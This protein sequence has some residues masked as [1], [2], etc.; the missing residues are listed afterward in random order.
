MNAHRTTKVAHATTCASASMQ[1]LS[2]T[3]SLTLF[4]ALCT[5]RMCVLS[6]RQL[7]TELGTIEA[8][9]RPC[10]AHEH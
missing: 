6:P 2:P 9:N 7:A 1:Q 10:H 3:L 8:S 4:Q 5:L